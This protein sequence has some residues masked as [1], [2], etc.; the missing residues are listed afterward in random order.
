MFQKLQVLLQG[1]LLFE[2]LDE[3]LYHTQ[4]RFHALELELQRDGLSQ[5]NLLEVFGIFSEN[6]KLSDQPEVRQQYEA[7]LV[8]LQL[9]QLNLLCLLL[10]CD[11]LQRFRGYFRP[12]IH[13]DEELEQGDRS[14]LLPNR[15]GKEL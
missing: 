14:Q 2:V 9:D 4:V 5:E 1:G 15:G 3:K 11:Q 12:G 13:L 6:V 10:T 7:K 8:L